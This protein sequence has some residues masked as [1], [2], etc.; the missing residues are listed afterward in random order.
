[1]RKRDAARLRDERDARVH[2][3]TFNPTKSLKYIQYATRF[4]FFTAEGEVDEGKRISYALKKK[5]LKKL[6]ITTKVLF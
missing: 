1:M 4:V 5:C 2:E 6:F 3:E